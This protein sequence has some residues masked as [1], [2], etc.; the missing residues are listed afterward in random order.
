MTEILINL[1]WIIACLFTSMIIIVGA[2]GFSVVSKGFSDYKF[3][4]P[5]FA[6]FVMA[7]ALVPIIVMQL[8]AA[9]LGA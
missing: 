2:I 7:S 4:Q 6:L 5:L 1:G 9:W 3:I 8:I